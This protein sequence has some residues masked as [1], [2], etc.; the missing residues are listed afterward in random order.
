MVAVSLICLQTVARLGLEESRKAALLSE[1]S[2]RKN[3]H[4]Q[5]S[6]EWFSIQCVI[7]SIRRIGGVIFIFIN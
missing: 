5:V 4:V 3:Y 6:C 2:A 7:A 1:S